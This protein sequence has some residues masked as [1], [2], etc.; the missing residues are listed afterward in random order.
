MTLLDEITRRGKLPHLK[1]LEIVMPT[2]W[3]KLEKLTNEF[4]DS[5]ISKSFGH[6]E[7]TCRSK[8]DVTRKRKSTYPS[9]FLRK[10]SKIHLRVVTASQKWIGTPTR[11]RTSKFSKSFGAFG[12]ASWAILISPPQRAT[13]TIKYLTLIMS[14]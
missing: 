14:D 10:F 7:R 6:F 13:P 1:A 11:G 5:E 2:N 12:A 9:M 8:K 3:I 4:I